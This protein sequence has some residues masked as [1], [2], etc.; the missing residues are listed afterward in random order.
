MEQARRM[1]HQTRP[2]GPSY[3]GRTS[4]VFAYD[5][6]RYSESTIK[7]GKREQTGMRWKIILAQELLLLLRL[8]L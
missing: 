5:F 6:T 8:C 1:S 2:P 3:W 7:E 4:H